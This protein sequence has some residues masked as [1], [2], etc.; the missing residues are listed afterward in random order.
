[1]HLSPDLE[2]QLRALWN[3]YIRHL[4]LLNG[5]ILFY[6]LAWIWCVTFVAIMQLCAIAKL[7]TLFFCVL[8]H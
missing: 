5:N 8:P 4:W 7:V 2:Y 6:F 1:M 3:Y